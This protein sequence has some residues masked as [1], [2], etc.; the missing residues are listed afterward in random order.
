M[1]YVYMKKFIII[2]VDLTSVEGHNYEYDT[3]I[4]KLAIKEKF[5]VSIGITFYLLVFSW[6]FAFIF[7]SLQIRL[8]SYQARI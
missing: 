5:K 8:N 3:R 2:D 1:G 4:S 7:K 6:N